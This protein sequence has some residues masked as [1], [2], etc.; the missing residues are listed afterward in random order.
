[1]TI[2]V[3]TADS[4]YGTS[5]ISLETA[6]DLYEGGLYK[7]IQEERNWISHTIQSNKDNIKVG[8]ELLKRIDAAGIKP[9]KE[10]NNG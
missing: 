7:M 2:R 6:L 10:S 1:M 5:V 3:R 9:L 4:K 8:Q